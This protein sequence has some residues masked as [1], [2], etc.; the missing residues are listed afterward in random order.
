MS[1]TSILPRRSRRA[2][3]AR[4]DASVFERWARAGV[5]RRLEGLVDGRIRVVGRS[6][7][8]GIRTQALAL[9]LLELSAHLCAGGAYARERPFQR[10]H[11][12]VR[13]AD[14]EEAL[15]DSGQVQV[16]HGSF[17]F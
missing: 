17:G 5:E 6:Q 11:E 4:G 14:G 13:F 1:T 2:R 8:Q 7:V 9:Q 12:R 16:I 10:W 15:P 3:V